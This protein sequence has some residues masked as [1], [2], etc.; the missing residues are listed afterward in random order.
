MNLYV[1][2]SHT[3]VIA[4][5]PPLTQLDCHC[6]SVQCLSLQLVLGEVV[7]VAVRGHSPWCHDGL[8]L[9]Y[10]RVLISGCRTLGCSEREALQKPSQVYILR[11]QGDCYNGLYGNQCVRSMCSSEL[12]HT[13]YSTRVPYQPEVLAQTYST[14]PNCTV[15]VYHII[16]MS[17]QTW[18]SPACQ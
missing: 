2:P 15:T 13:S 5:S 4:P 6:Y 16:I 8:K 1:L 14:V 17:F 7:F 11:L 12:C 18:L 9:C 3:F 10:G